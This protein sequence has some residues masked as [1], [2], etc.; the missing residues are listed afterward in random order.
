[1]PLTFGGIVSGILGGYF[2]V[3]VADAFSMINSAKSAP[4]ANK[5]N[6]RQRLNG[7]G[8]K[9]KLKIIKQPK[10]QKQPTLPKELA[11][12]EAQI[13]SDKTFGPL[14]FKVKLSMCYFVNIMH[15]VLCL[16][17]KI[18]L[19]CVLSHLFCL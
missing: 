14:I 10:K 8:N 12:Y 11:Q 2:E 17:F 4:S 19:V 7:G 1:M 16:Y 3:P 13:R 5:D 18:C 9:S 15:L 6:S